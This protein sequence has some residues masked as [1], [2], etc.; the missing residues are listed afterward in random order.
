MSRCTKNGSSSFAV[1][2]YYHNGTRRDAR[3]ALFDRVHALYAA[4]SMQNP[5]GVLISLG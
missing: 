3:H 4:E 2:F 5:G 1:L